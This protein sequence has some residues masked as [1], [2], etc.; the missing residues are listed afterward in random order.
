M[1]ET[2]FH[3][4]HGVTFLT[5]S[6]IGVFFGTLGAAC[7]VAGHTAA[8]R[9]ESYIFENEF[10]KT[11]GE[12]EPYTEEKV[13]RTSMRVFIEEKFCPVLFFALCA[14]IGYFVG[15]TSPLVAG[16]GTAGMNFGSETIVS[17]AMWS[18]AFVAASRFQSFFAKKLLMKKAFGEKY[19]DFASRLHL[20]PIL[21][22]ATIVSFVVHA[23]N[24]TSV[25]AAVLSYA[26]SLF[27]VFFFRTARLVSNM[28][29]D[30]PRS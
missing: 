28:N 16:S 10:A 11:H 23:S 20:L 30:T 14:S 17:G 15:K 22:S 29:A 27:V 5:E 24:S 8:S 6:I 25:A 26:I 1:V 9:L 19:R 4:V 13:G 2:F 3:G 12:T 18:S 21:L 7:I